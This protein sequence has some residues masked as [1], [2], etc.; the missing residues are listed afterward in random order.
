MILCA[1]NNKEC[2][3]ECRE[4]H[5]FRVRQILECCPAANGEGCIN[6][7]KHNLKHLKEAFV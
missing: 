6:G 3:G 1:C 2:K 4:K 5:L 7:R